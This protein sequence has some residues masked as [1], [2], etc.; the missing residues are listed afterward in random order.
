MAIHRF[1]GNKHGAQNTI[2]HLEDESRGQAT[3]G[4][5]CRE[6]GSKRGVKG[7]AGSTADI[8]IGGRREM[9]VKTGEKEKRIH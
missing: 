2:F 3:R 4:E 8:G 9:L 5:N 7:T 6:V 1:G